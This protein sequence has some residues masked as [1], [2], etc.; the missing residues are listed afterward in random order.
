MR[1]DLSI[2]ADNPQKATQSDLA[3][4]ELLIIRS[5]RRTIEWWWAS[6]VIF[7]LQIPE[8]WKSNT[9]V[10]SIVESWLRTKICCATRGASS[11]LKLQA[12]AI[13]P[14]ASDRDHSNLR[15]FWI[16]TSEEFIGKGQLEVPLSHNSN[17]L[18]HQICM[19]HRTMAEG[20]LW[21]I[22]RKLMIAILVFHRSASDWPG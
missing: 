22:V 4:L 19:S 7:Q 1:L 12:V 5:L 6:C 2:A 8:Q 17:E 3:L 9:K 13:V 10:L 16:F 21:L 11:F 15:E 20:E 18:L 14:R